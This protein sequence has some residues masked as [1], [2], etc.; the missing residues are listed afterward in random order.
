MQKK[1]Q[2]F[3]NTFIF[4]PSLLHIKTSVRKQLPNEETDEG[5]VGGMEGEKL[6]LHQD[7]E[8]QKGRSAQG[9]QNVS[10]S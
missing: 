6:A 4:I 2:E 9:K 7:G 5:H 3:A 1:S 10:Y 8:Q